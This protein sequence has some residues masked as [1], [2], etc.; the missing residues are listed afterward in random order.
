[1]GLIMPT[2]KIHTMSK[3]MQTITCILILMIS[4]TEAQQTTK[5]QNMANSPLYTDK[6]FQYDNIFIGPQPQYN[7][8]AA[9]KAAGFVK[10]INTRTPKEMEALEFNQNYVLKKAGIEY[11]FIALGGEE[12]KYS[13]AKLQKFAQSLEAANGK[14]LLHCRSGHRVSQL[15]AAYLVKYKDKTPD[16]ALSMVSAMGWW[17]MP[18]ELLLD[19]KLYVS[20]KK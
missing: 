12:F 1:M 19:K 13:P 20:L 2:E 17:P 9:I 11:D 5:K 10:V 3:Y 4:N 8:F 16:E 18:M 14:V 15:W 6:L 7:D